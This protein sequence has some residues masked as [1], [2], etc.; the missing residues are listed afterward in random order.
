MFKKIFATFSG[1]AFGIGILI[2]GCLTVATL[3][4]YPQLPELNILTE[5]QPKIP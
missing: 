5:Y 3:I 4:T 1:L 2:A